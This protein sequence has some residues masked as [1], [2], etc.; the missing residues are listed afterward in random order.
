MNDLDSF[1]QRCID[2]LDEHAT[3]IT[4]TEADDPR[5]ELTHQQCVAFQ[6]AAAAAGLAGLQYPVEYGGQ[7][8][9]AEH[10]R[11]WREEAS[12]HPLMTRTLSITQGMCLPML[13][14]YGTHQQRTRHQP[15]LISATQV[16]CQMFSEPGAG[17][18]VASLQMRAIRD[19]D[20]WIINGQKVWTTLAHVADRGI[21]IARTDP[22]QPKHRGISMFIIDMHAP[23]VEIR[24]IHQIDGGM[25]FNEVYLTDVR[26]P[27][28][29]QIGELNQGWRLATAM[30][31]YER[32]AIGTGQ[33]GGVQ[34]A[35]TDKL[36]RAAR[37]RNNL[38]SP[39]LRQSL[40][41]MYSAEVCQS[42]MGMRTRAEDQA[43]KTPGPG[44]SLG[45]LAGA[46]IAAMYRDLSLTI[47]GPGAV[48]GEDNG[49]WGLEALT[50]FAPGIAGGTNEI[51]RNIIGERVLGLPRE[52]SVDKDLPFKQLSISPQR[53]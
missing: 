38:H 41:K 32:V 33:T 20:E 14:E 25:R 44:G 35:R 8:L 27:A 31:M 18:D 29:D 4:V 47:V 19:G 10:Q 15:D 37:K 12:K 6:Q 2:F 43:G 24:P 22:D 53:D 9:G 28:E 46:R 49:R 5:H 48:A 39:V 17:S 13:N 42:L 36:I 3:G 21:V 52:P 30:L 11:I 23:G 51:Q 45:K 50:T 16:W 40:M 1:R 26:V 34:H 7:D